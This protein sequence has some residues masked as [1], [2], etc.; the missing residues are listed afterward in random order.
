M[1]A[2]PIVVENLSKTFQVARRQS[3]FSASVRHFFRRETEDV[4]AV[5]DATFTV[6]RGEFVGVLGKNGAGK[7]TIL[8]MLAGLIH[9]TSG[10]ASVLG[11]NPFRRNRAHLKR[12][13][14]VMG[15]RQ[16]LIWDLPAQDSYRI[17]AALYGLDDDKVKKRVHELAEMLLLE[18]KNLAQPVRKLSLGQRMKAELVAALLHEPEVLFLDEPT[19]G[20]DVSVQRAL[21]DFLRT[22]NE[23][24]EATV[25]LTSHYMADVTALCPRILLFQDGALSYDG[26]LQTFLDD[27]APHRLVEL[28]L[29]A[30]VSDEALKEI[31]VFTREGEQVCFQV[32]R[33]E[34]ASVTAVLLARYESSDLTVRDIDVDDIVRDA[35]SEAS[36]LQ[37]DNEAVTE[38]TETAT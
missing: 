7:T 16:Q 6:E 36:A 2:A 22:Y 4:H 35:F 26:G 23:E 33:E 32:P 28:S 8:K 15:N 29:S 1:P 17:H 11:Q 25:L 24:T 10:K 37:D 30:G 20:L 27:K 21:R 34:I 18:E 3:G 5:R 9:P 13:S 38:K 19:L 14:L 31:G 12:I